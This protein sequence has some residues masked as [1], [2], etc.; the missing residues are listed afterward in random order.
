MDQKQ[1]AAERIQESDWTPWADLPNTDVLAHSEAD[2][3]K[4]E[5]AARLIRN[6]FTTPAGRKTLDWLVGSFS[7]RLVEPDNST[8]A[9]YRAGQANVVSQILYQMHIAEE[10]IKHE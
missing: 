7:V 3:A 4:Y 8:Q 6:T 1:H 9:A 2:Q 5:S 10:G